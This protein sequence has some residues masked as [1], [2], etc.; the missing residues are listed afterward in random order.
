MVGSSEDVRVVARQVRRDAERV[1]HVAA[2]VGATRGVAWRS[3]AA[4]RFREVVTDRVVALGR[5]VGGLES[6]A[7]ALESHALA[8]D[9]ARDALR[10]L[11]GEVP[12]PGGRR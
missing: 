11:L 9:R 8:L 2:R 7:D 6:A 10:A 4:T 12:G 5:A 1:R 3:A